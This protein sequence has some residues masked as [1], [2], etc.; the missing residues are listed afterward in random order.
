M[1]FLELYYE[2]ML[3][4]HLAIFLDRYLHQML[5]AT[6]VFPYFQ[7]MLRLLL[8]N[9]RDYQLLFFATLAMHDQAKA[10]YPH[11]HYVPLEQLLLFVYQ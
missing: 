1:D 7:K 10:I 8:Y 3:S 4:S 11:I 5:L 2:K 6:P 9:E